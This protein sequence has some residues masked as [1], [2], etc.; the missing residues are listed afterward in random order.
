MRLL[1]AG[2]QLH[3]LRGRPVIAAPVPAQMEMSVGPGVSR[4]AMAGISVPAN[5]PKGGAGLSGAPA[6]GAGFVPSRVARE[7]LH[8]RP[9]R[10]RLWDEIDGEPERVLTIRRMPAGG[11][12]GSQM[13]VITLE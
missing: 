4:I 2:D 3:G 13:G 1:V 7:A 10:G 6:G 5:K 8:L 11:V 9:R 12:A